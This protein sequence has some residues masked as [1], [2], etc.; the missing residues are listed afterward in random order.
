MCTVCIKDAEDSFNKYTD[1]FEKTEKGIDTANEIDVGLW[2]NQKAFYI[3]A[4]E[5]KERTR[6]LLQIIINLWQKVQDFHQNSLGMIKN[7]IRKYTDE[8]KKVITFSAEDII[9]K[10]FSSLIKLLADRYFI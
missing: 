6:K 10:V 2:I 7:L 4:K 5:I 9:A 8:R 3:K 1:I